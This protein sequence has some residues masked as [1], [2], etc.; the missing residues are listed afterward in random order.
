MNQPYVM[1]GLATA[2][3]ISTQTL[4]TV[5]I[6]VVDGYLERLCPE[7]IKDAKVV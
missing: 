7:D 5:T 4:S 3:L 1:D 6:L 2:F